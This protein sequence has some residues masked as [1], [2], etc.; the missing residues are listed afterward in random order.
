MDYFV[1]TTPKRRHGHAVIFKNLPKRINKKKVEIAKQ[2]QKKEI[3]L[4]KMM[5]CEN[6]DCNSACSEIFVQ[7]S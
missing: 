7:V 2:L 3:S 1:I 6:N 5:P 4:K